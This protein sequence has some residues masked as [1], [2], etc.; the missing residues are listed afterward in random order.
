MDL[1]NSISVGY[2]LLRSS[3]ARASLLFP[4]DE[5]LWLSMILGSTVSF[6]TNYD[7]TVA[8]GCKQ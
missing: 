5:S 6:L 3:I 7:C 2:G 1:N 8:I 4:N